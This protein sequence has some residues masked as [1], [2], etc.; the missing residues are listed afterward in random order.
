MDLALITGF[1]EHLSLLK[2]GMRPDKQTSEEEEKR[3]KR[4]KFTER[5]VINQWVYA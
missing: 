5:V 1:V 3:Q 4:N 2:Q